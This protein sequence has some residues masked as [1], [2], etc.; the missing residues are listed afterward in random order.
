MSPS[1]STTLRA[2]ATLAVVLLS[3]LGVLFV[4]DLIPRETLQHYAVKILLLIAIIAGA[5]RVLGVLLRKER[6]P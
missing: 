1:M 3:L 2:A 4:F 5:G 6:A